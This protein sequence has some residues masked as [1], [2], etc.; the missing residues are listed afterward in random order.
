LIPPRHFPYCH[1]IHP[2][3]LF[4]SLCSCSL[5]SSSHHLDPSLSPFRSFL[6]LFCFNSLIQEKEAHAAW[7]P[8]ENQLCRKRRRTASRTPNSKILDS[9]KT[10]KHLVIVGFMTHIPIYLLLYKYFYFDYFFFFLS[11]LFFHHFISFHFIFYYIILFLTMF[12]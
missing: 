6:H 11:I 9:Y 4:L 10:I 2:L 5:L 8:Q 12:T 3:Y 7:P 1:Y